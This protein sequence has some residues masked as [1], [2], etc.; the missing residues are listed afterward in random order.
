MTKEVIKLDEKQ[1]VTAEVRE[2]SGKG[3]A[4]KLRA[5][6]KIPATLYGYRLEGAK[7]LVLDP[8]R[9]YEVL[10]TKRRKNIVFRLDVDGKVLEDVM[11]KEYQIDPVKRDLLHCDLV[12]IDP[13]KPVSVLVPAEA[14]GRAKGVRAGGRLQMVRDRIPVRCLPNDIPLFIEHD[15]TKLAMGHAVL[16]SEL[17]LPEGVEPDWPVDFAVV[18]VAIPRGA[19]LPEDSA[20][21]D[22]E[23]E[24]EESDE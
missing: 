23:G 5:A 9:M 21:E 11:V 8:E 16:A 19:N 6:G 2:A 18:R 22:E 7:S 10:M 13:T 20:D 17:K 3:V 12:A 24:S 1:T 14:V 4:R 15:V